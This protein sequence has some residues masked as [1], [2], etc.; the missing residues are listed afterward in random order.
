MHPEPASDD[1][2]FM[3]GIEGKSGIATGRDED[4]ESRKGARS[5]LRERDRR[6]ALSFCCFPKVILGG[7]TGREYW[8]ALEDG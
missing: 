6:V 3:D 5:G 1:I 8:P 7:V 2:T 4:G